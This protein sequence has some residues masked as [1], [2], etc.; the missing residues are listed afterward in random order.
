MKN[1]TLS[2]FDA[3]QLGSYRLIVSLIAI[4][5]VSSVVMWFSTNLIQYPEHDEFAYFANALYFSGLHPYTSGLAFNGETYSVAYI[6]RPPLLWWL[7]TGL[8]SMGI[9]PYVA[10]VVSP[11]FSVLG[12]L[13]IAQMA[14]EFTGEVKSAL[15]AGLLAGVSGFAASVSARVLSD[16]I[17]S[18]FALLAVFSFYEYFMKK[19]RPYIVVLGMALGLGLVSRDEDLVTFILLILMWILFVSNGKPVRR[20]VYAGALGAFFGIPVLLFGLA[21]T[22][23]MVSD[24]AT[25]IVL[26]GW[27]LILFMGAILTYVTFKPKGVRFTELSAGFFVFFL[28]MLPF[29]YDNFLLGNVYYYIAGKG[30]LARPVAHLLMVPLTGNV[31]AN[32]PERVRIMDWVSSVPALLSVPVVCAA[33][34]GLYHMFKSSARKFAFLFLWLIVTLGFVVTE[35]NLEDRFLFIAFAPV[36]IL[37]GIGLSYVWKTSYVIGV[38]AAIPTF[39]LADVVPRAPIS[40]SNL[41]IFRAIFGGS[42]N[43]IFVFLPSVPLSPPAPFLPM[44]YMLDGLL[45]IPFA[46]LATILGAYTLRS[47]RIEPI[48]VAPVP[49]SER[50]ERKP[51]AL[52]QAPIPAA[53]AVPLSSSGSTEQKVTA[54]SSR[55]SRRSN[56]DRAGIG[57]VQEHNSREGRRVEIL[58]RNPSV[59]V[60]LPKVGTSMGNQAEVQEN[61]ELG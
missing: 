52:P 17:G 14:Y 33:A 58:N 1:L 37:A 55:Y 21:N 19:R 43:W 20:L 30:V 8:F 56:S 13:V 25:P 50:E 34:L 48:F 49:G 46:I 41:T 27:P 22:L 44:A 7:L 15:F 12:A 40:L 36:M 26:N 53:S 2:N 29:L 6:E 35:T 51:V 11:L 4:G 24:F 23:Q 61:D 57:S 39:F 10:L 32:L 54:S 59:K 18:F 38:L 47:K 31:G 9:T 60:A 3:L 45:S 5:A 16:S 28:V 42:Q